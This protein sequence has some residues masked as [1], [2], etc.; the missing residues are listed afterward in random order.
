LVKNA[1][2]LLEEDV[3]EIEVALFVRIPGS[4]HFAHFLDGDVTVVVAKGVVNHK[5]F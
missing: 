5:S 1:N 4:R 2:K 3:T